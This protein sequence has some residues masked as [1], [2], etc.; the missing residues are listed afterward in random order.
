MLY[1]HRLIV[2]TINKEH[3]TIRSM[4]QKYAFIKFAVLKNETNLV[5]FCSCPAFVYLRSS[6]SWESH[7]FHSKTVQIHV[8]I[9]SQLNI[10]CA[11]FLVSKQLTNIYG[12]LSGSRNI[13]V[14]PKLTDSVD[15]ILS[16]LMVRHNFVLCAQQSI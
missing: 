7:T 6:D 16:F 15:L 14:S 11:V 10:V 13:K 1:N 5:Y 2:P 8:V 12:G 9:I 3:H 4:N